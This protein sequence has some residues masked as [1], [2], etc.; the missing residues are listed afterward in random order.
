MTNAAPALPGT[1]CPR[2]QTSNAPGAKFCAS[3][4]TPLLAQ[5]YPPPPPPPPAS[6]GGRGLLGG[7]GGGGESVSLGVDPNAAYQTLLQ[8][9]QAGGGQV[10][11]QTPPQQAQFVMPQKH[12]AHGWLPAKVKASAT[13][14]PVGPGQ[15]SVS[16][17]ARTDWSSLILYL[18][19]GA[20]LSLIALIVWAVGA[21]L[22]LGSMLALL[23]GF[24]GLGIC[25]VV[26]F[27]VSGSTF[28]A[29]AAKAI[30]R[31]VQTRAGFGGGY[32]S[33]H[34][35]AAPPPTPL[36]PVPVPASQAAPDNPRSSMEQLKQLAELRDAGAI[37][38]DDFERKKAELLA[39]I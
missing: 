10:T 32:Q 39:R 5:A 19:G 34:V 36:R 22:V 29:A 7:V 31:E 35:S 20:V 28:P 9:V 33:A 14:S 3:C 15:S 23:T 24:L 17:Q 11:F 38:A 18:A 27:V 16:I 6:F 30:A 26:Q 12:W 25:W 4:G 13:V 37:S 2:C 8:V 1:S 21:G